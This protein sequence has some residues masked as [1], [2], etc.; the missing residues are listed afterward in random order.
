MEYKKGYENFNIAA[1]IIIKWYEQTF[2]A[3]IV[4]IKSSSRTDVEL[5]GILLAAKKQ[6]LGILTVLHNEHLLSTHAL[7]RTL[8]EIHVVLLW[9]LNVEEKEK[10]SK[11]LEVYKRLKRWDLTRLEEDEKLFKNLP[12]NDNLKNL[13]DQIS[14]DINKLK[15][16]GIKVLPNC[17]D[18]Y[19]DLGDEWIDVYSFYRKYSQAVH[20]NRNSTQ[21]LAWMQNRNGKSEAILYKDDI[22]SNGDELLDV[23][24][25]SCDINM[26]V[27]I[28]YDWHVDSMKKE[29]EQLK[30]KI[31][32]K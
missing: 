24:S 21:Q 20:L 19:K 31:E 27:R 15:R 32:E 29:Y 2:N 25:V 12:Q 30:L 17:H 16:E 8:I 14:E 22:E 13:I 9:A 4:T 3:I 26:A 11:S 10:E 7:L 28:Y 23:A 6:T 18:L 1:D 5:L